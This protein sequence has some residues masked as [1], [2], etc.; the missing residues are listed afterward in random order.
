MCSLEVRKSLVSQ[1]GEVKIFPAGR[2]SIEVLGTWQ[3]P[4]K[5][6][7]LNSL[8]DNDPF[9]MQWSSGTFRGHLFPH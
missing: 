5:E 6:I 4:F 1:I 9:R 8:L 7:I 2:G 3:W